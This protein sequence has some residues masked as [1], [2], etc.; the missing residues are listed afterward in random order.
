MTTATTIQSRI[1]L[2]RSMPLA[3]IAVAAVMVLVLLLLAP[4]YGFHG[5]EMYFV[6]AGRHPAFGYVDQPPLTPLLSAASAALLGV[7]PFSIRVLP[8]LE[9]AL[10]VVIIALIARDLGGSRRSQLI[11]A[12]VAALSGYLGAG[13]LDTTTEPDLLAWALIMWLLVR[14][15]AG[16][17]R[18]LW[19]AVGLVAG[20]ALENKDTI[21]FFGAGL[22]VALVLSRRWDVVGSPWAWAAVG[23]AILLWLPNLTW[24]A[25]NGWPQLAMAQA[26]SSYADENRAQVVPLLWLFTGP[27]L[28]PVSIAGL[29]WILVASDARPWRALGIGSLVAL[30]LALVSGGKA[31]YVI[32][33]VPIFMAAGAIVVDR[34]LDR[35]HAFAKLTVLAVAAVLSGAGIV[36]LTLPVLPLNSYARSGLP[37]AVPD[38]ANTIGW[39]TFVAT[40][41][42]VV[43]ALPPDQRDRAVI[44]ANDYSEASALELL[45]SNLPPVYSGHNAYWMWGPPT[46]DRTVVIHVGDWRPADWRRYFTGCTDAAAVDNGLGIANAEQGTVVSV[47]TGLEQP[48]SWMWPALRTIS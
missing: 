20:I 28:F 25:A 14:L 23:I 29:A 41:Q 19:L 3:V 13:H 39:P 45:G 6:V 46:D 10:V 38:V 21:L 16:G 42:G 47:C 9:V 4:A 18:R 27:L 1:S 12:V 5:D 48:W 15:L 8:A 11:G 34:W 24:Q 35:G 26:I 32:G 33:S 31:Y 43:D 17:D 37:E 40:V 7:S 44:L 2:S 22:A 36:L 30:A